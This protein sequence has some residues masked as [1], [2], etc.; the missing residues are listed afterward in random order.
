MLLLEIDKT[1]AIQYTIVA[2]I[3]IA[4]IVRIIIG[5]RKIHKRSARGEGGCC[6]CTLA[7]NCTRIPKK[8]PNDD[9]PKHDCNVS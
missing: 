8:H 3:I 5:L 1:Y 2:I 9:T 7:D 6:G 4:A